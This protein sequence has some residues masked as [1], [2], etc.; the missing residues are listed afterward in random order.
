MAKFRI[1]W[2]YGRCRVSWEERIKDLI[3]SI[4]H[5]GREEETV[6]EEASFDFM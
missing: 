2:K 4:S 1:N 3:V 5:Y 6:I